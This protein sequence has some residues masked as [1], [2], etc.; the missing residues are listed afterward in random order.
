MKKKIEER[1]YIRIVYSGLTMNQVDQITKAIQDHEFRGKLNVQIYSEWERNEEGKR[2]KPTGLYEV[3]IT[4]FKGVLNGNIEDKEEYEGWFK[5]VTKTAE[6][7][8]KVIDEA[9]K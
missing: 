5:F 2:T 3:A 7:F 1:H 4:D 8:S 6:E 9:L